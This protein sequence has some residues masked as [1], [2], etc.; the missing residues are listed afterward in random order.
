[1]I[2]PDF[3][4]MYIES[5]CV[6]PAMVHTTDESIEPNILHSPLIEPY[7]NYLPAFGE[8]KKGP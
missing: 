6:F 2:K 4:K 1:M 8:A 7:T 3:D 5:G